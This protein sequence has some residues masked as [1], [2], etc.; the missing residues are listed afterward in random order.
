[1][2]TT[3]N[4]VIHSFWAPNLHG[5]RDLIPGHLTTTWLQADRPG[6][7]RG[8]CAEFCGHQ[9]AHMSFVVIAEQPDEFYAWLDAQRMPAPQPAG[10]DEQHGQQVFLSSTCIMCHTVQ[11]TRANGRVAPDLT[12]VASRR[13]IAAGALANT[14]DNLA[15]WIVDSQ[16][17]KPG[18]KM[19]PHNLSPGDLQALL[20]YLESLK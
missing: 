4:D 6:L 19:P 11:G 17:I 9:H 13:L 8:Q 18:N 14:R 2:I 16:R 10:P 15:D 3:S 20:S 7:F 5:K 1:L 12:H